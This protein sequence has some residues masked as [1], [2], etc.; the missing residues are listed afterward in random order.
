M[1][2]SCRRPKVLWVGKAWLVP[3]EVDG[4]LGGRPGDAGLIPEDDALIATDGLHISLAYL[5]KLRDSDFEKIK[6]F[7]DMLTTHIQ[8]N[9]DWPIQDCAER[10][11][12]ENERCSSIRIRMALGTCKPERCRECRH[13]KTRCPEALPGINAFD[14]HLHARERS[15]EHL[16]VL[17]GDFYC[18]GMQKFLRSQVQPC[19]AQFVE[20]LHLT[21]GDVW[22]NV[23]NHTDTP[24]DSMSRDLA[25]VGDGHETADD[26]VPK[27]SAR[28]GSAS[29]RGADDVR[30]GEAD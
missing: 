21:V 9:G 26:D 24:T 20:E 14:T 1:V 22:K 19:E 13:F 4:Q 3:R 15:L 18:R 16:A 10:W 8:Y 2:L 28:N 7:A 23:G 12:Y 6:S 30:H 29:D 17:C 25:A 5:G 27:E 11:Q